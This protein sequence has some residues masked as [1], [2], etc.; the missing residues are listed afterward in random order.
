MLD[1]ASPEGQDQDARSAGGLAVWRGSMQARGR[2]GLGIRWAGLW[3][4]LLLLLGPGMPAC[5]EYDSLSDA[6]LEDGDGGSDAAGDPSD[7]TDEAQATDGDE[8]SQDD[9]L[10][11]ADDGNG[12]GDEGGVGDGADGDDGADDQDGED[13]EDGADQDPGLPSVCPVCM[14]DCEGKSC[15][16]DGCGGDCGLCSSSSGGSTCMDNSC[17]WADWGDCLGKQC[18]PDGMG[19]SCGT[20]SAGWVCATYGKCQ[21]EQGGCDAVPAGGLCMA[22]WVVRCEAGL[23]TYQ[24]CAFETCETDPD[25][26]EARC[27]PVPCLPRCFG[28]TCGDDGC[29]G[30]CGACGAGEVCRED[31][32]GCLPE[33]GCGQVGEA[34]ACEGHVL[35]TCQAGA[36][37]TEECLP[38]RRLCVPAE[39]GTRAGCCPPRP[40]EPCDGLPTYNQ[41]V[42]A[43]EDETPWDN[44]SLVYCASGRLRIDACYWMMGGWC[45]RTGMQR[46]GCR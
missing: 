32:G 44:D 2:D 13:G 40:D 18:G 28:R 23:L 6:A 10:S 37:V 45:T 21:P 17:V 3:A 39:P 14:P 35:L 41:C 25:T 7:A 5:T 22:G 20:C 30:S 11:F 36:I 42:R 43:P 33:A 24:E 19:G 9:G 15:G 12:P 46:Y 38:Q 27:T 4:I 8:G 26:Q 1:P 16:S 31:L 29:G 34:G